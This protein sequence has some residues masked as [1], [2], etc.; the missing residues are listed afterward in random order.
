[1]LMFFR[2]SGSLTLTSHDLTAILYATTALGVPIRS[3]MK[4]N[5][6]N[7]SFIAVIITVFDV[8][9]DNRHQ[10]YSK[11]LT[12]RLSILGPFIINP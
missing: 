9:V 8:T 2:L 10:I 4:D 7:I 11:S 5:Q 12:D 1:M 6:H 3:I